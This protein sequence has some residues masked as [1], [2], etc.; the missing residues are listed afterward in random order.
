MSRLLLLVVSLLAGC[1]SRTPATKAPTPVAEDADHVKLPESAPRASDPN[2]VERLY[3]IAETEGAPMLGA[4][5]AKVK[6]EVCSDFQC[7]YCAQLAPTLRELNENYG[8]LLR[9]VW[10]NCPLPI[11]ERALP[12]AEAALEVQAQRGNAA[13]WAYHDQLFA[14]QNELGDD[15]LIELARAIE[16]IDAERVRA[17]L[18]DHRHRRHIQK[19]LVA[20]VDAGATAH[21][22][23]T[24]AVFVN[25][26]MFMGAQPYRVFE[27]AVE[28]ALQEL[29]DQR[30]H[31]ESA[32]KQA[33]PMARVRH[34]LIQYE[35]AKNASPKLTRT[36]EEALLR[37]RSLQQQL[38]NEHADFGALAH[39]ASECPS[40][41]EGG[42]LGRFTLGELDPS[43]E[44]ALFALS[45]GQVSEVVETSFGYHLL[46]REE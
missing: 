29:P 22:L 37:A 19:E 6:L 10:R 13:F 9:I 41:K 7:P 17:A 39:E 4:A 34:I 42:E 1:A 16:G 44:L 30:A 40:G 46:L 21:G 12:A 33:Y 25:G 2:D 32:S 26:R 43:F 36:K 27:D 15:A 3:D 5:D 31:A 24:P 20:V 35:G 11:H 14:H 45:P 38:V 8:E 23:G 28:R 18:T